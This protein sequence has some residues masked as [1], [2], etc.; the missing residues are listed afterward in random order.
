MTSLKATIKVVLLGSEGV[1]KS[2][3]LNRFV[4]NDFKEEDRKS[5]V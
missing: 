2:S 3:I 1:G 4:Y 5:V